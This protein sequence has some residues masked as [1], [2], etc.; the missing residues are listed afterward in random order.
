MSVIKV[1]KS[2]V[3]CNKWLKSDYKEFVDWINGYDKLHM[4]INGVYYL[5]SLIVQFNYFYIVIMN[6]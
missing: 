3:L 6:V 5:I 1:K 4:S 2:G